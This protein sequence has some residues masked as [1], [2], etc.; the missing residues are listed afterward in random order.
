VKRIALLLFALL[1]FCVTSGLAQDTITIGFTQSNT[2]ALNVNSLEQYR[3][4]ELWRDHVNASGGIKVGGKSYKI[5]F[6]N[7]DDESNSKRVQQLYSRLIL[8][9]KSDFL[10]SPYSSG[11]TASAAVV[12]EQYGKIMLT[13]GAAEEKTYRL[14]NKY[15]FQMFAPAQHYLRVALDALKAIDPKAPV[16]FV[17]EDAAFSVAVVNQAK[18]YAQQQGFNTVFSEAYAPNTTDFG[19]ILDKVISS[20]ATVLLGGGHYADGSTLARQISARKAKLKMVTLL[21]APDSPKWVELGD[22]GIG[23]TVPSQWDPNLHVKPQF[24][25]TVAQF[26][27]D[28]AAK[29]NNEKPS[30]E[31]AGGYASGLILQH[32]IEKAGSLDA[33]K[34]AEALNATDAVTFYG[35]TKFATAP[36]EH[37]L[38]IGHSM[39]LSQW[40]NDKAGKP[41]KQVV[42]P[43]DVRSA[44]LQYPMK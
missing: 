43:T 17:Y 26:L 38:Q 9:D 37:G 10:F 40:Q 8:Q 19:P 4:F 12:T 24:G 44:K 42:W 6:V 31:S 13:T 3:G 15:L 34:V 36:N 11:L 30:Y 29:Y 5:K 39:I 1:M 22:A 14:G 7:Y 35:R 33:A 23:V 2:G 21:V 25:P 20:K 32:A 18:E 27:K 28:Y 41:V 16:A